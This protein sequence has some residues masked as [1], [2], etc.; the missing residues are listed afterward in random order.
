MP[1]FSFL[2]RERLVNAGSGFGVVCKGAG[3]VLTWMRSQWQN[4]MGLFEMLDAGCWSRA[5]ETEVDEGF[6]GREGIGVGFGDGG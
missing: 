3:Y 6:L 5:I 1:F 2:G 4:G